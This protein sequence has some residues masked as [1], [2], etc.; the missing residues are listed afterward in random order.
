MQTLSLSSPHAYVNYSSVVVTSSITPT[1]STVS[2]GQDATGPAVGA[3]A[4]VLGLIIVVVIV[5]VVVIVLKR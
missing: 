3:V 2:G 1:L 4:A 5:V